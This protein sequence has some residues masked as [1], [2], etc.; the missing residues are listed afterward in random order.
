MTLPL[1]APFRPPWR[2]RR[3]HRVVR[4]GL[5]QGYGPECAESLGLTPKTYRRRPTTQNDALFNLNE[6]AREMST[7]TRPVWT[8]TNDDLAVPNM[9]HV[10]PSFKPE[11]GLVFVGIGEGA[12]MSDTGCWPGAHHGIWLR[13]EQV[14]GL[15]AALAAVADYSEA[16]DED[17][18]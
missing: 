13:R 2:C 3:C 16:Y 5:V 7:T 12:A 4:T 15:R 8:Y 18:S 1:P 9:I 10:A 11:L 6:G 17:D 14:D